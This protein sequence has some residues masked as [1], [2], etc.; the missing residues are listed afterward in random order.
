MLVDMTMSTPHS[1]KRLAE[2]WSNIEKAQL[3]EAGV[4]GSGP[5][6][7]DWKRFN[8]D[9]MTFIL[10]LPPDRLVALCKLLNQ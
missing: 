1:L 10:K 3:V 2:R 7:S 8:D 5:G 6:G 9:P 4:I